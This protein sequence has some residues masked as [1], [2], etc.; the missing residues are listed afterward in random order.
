MRALFNLSAFFI[1][2][3]RK[4]MRDLKRKV[5]K[6]VVFVSAM[7]ILL[8]NVPLFANTIPKGHWYD[9]NIDDKVQY[10]LLDSHL[11][12]V[13]YSDGS[14]VRGSYDKVMEEAERL[15]KGVNDPSLFARYETFDSASYLNNNGYAVIVPFI[16][17]V[18]T[19]QISRC[20]NFDYGYPSLEEYD[21]GGDPTHDDLMNGALYYGY[22]GGDSSLQQKYGLPDNQT[23]YADGIVVW[24]HAKRLGIPGNDGQ[25]G[26]TGLQGNGTLSKDESNKLI[27]YIEEL[28]TKTISDVVEEF[29][30]VF[31]G[32]VSRKDPQKTSALSISASVPFSV[33]VTEPDT[34]I[35]MNGNQKTMFGVGEKFLV[36][37]KGSFIGNVSVTVK[38]E[39][40]VYGGLMFKAKRRG[41]QNV[42][43][44]GLRDPIILHKDIILDF[45]GAYDIIDIT[46]R[47]QDKELLPNTVYEIADNSNF[48]NSEKFTTDNNGHIHIEDLLLAGETLYIREHSA[49]I[50]SSHLG[51]NISPGTTV[52]QGIGGESH[53][54]EFEN[55][56]IKGKICINKT[57]QDSKPLHN[58]QFDLLRPDG[59]FLNTK[60][61]DEKGKL[62]FENLEL[63]LY[64]IVERVPDDYTGEQLVY[65]IDLKI[66]DVLVK[67]GNNTKSDY[68][69]QGLLDVINEKIVSYNP[70]I[71]TLAT[72]VNG[73]K[74]FK[75]NA[76]IEFIDYV[77]YTDLAPNKE[78]TLT[79][80][81]MDKAT[82]QPLLIDN[83]Q[84]TESITFTANK[85]NDTAE[86]YYKLN[87]TGLEG[88]DL[89][90]F[91][92][93]TQDDDVITT[94]EDINDT[95]QTI[96][97][98]S[99]PIALVSTGQRVIELLAFGLVLM[100]VS[101]VV[102]MR[103]RKRVKQDVT[104][105]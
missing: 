4:D 102:L 20:L 60:T 67:Q 32:E 37:A 30:I 14:T 17:N 91:E 93:L 49:P 63:G 15:I 21:E 51:Y 46:K 48:E 64:R 101:V 5:N 105:D 86:V 69:A 50:I 8:V 81:I 11:N 13:K 100:G 78:Y 55:K 35:D 87:T 97:I 92:T 53:N 59:R 71:K 29:N 103:R 75:P 82:G 98:E 19:G 23:I 36:Q 40:V 10:E 43:D 45:K 44:L 74:S 18:A 65:D 80:L 95:G 52:V 104:R 38:T 62:C 84:I 2:K 3:N 89:V 47:T 68:V 96:R 66:D 57:D 12:T 94:H 83:E 58:V 9:E 41:A 28:A 61:T 1:G 56:K 85:S 70:I 42:I 25:T 27:A 26:F 7:L 22:G 16:R 39:R 54:F 76:E 24:R 79:G 90:V 99:K 73:E 77:E 6:I 33:E 31:D 72:G 88:K 34:V